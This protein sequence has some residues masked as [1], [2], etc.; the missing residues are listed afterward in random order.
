MHL[1]NVLVREGQIKIGF[2]KLNPRGVLAAGGNMLSS[3]LFIQLLNT[4]NPLTT[5]D[6]VDPW[7]SCCRELALSCVLRSGLSVGFQG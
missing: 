6:L 4:L 1:C 3:V 7:R 2:V 5:S